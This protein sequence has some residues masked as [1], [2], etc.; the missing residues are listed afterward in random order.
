MAKRCS[1][2]RGSKTHGR[3]KRGGAMRLQGGGRKK[4]MR[5]RRRSRRG[6]QSMM[7]DGFAYSYTQ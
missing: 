7:R 4:M 6:G 5:T 3:T 2:R 1:K